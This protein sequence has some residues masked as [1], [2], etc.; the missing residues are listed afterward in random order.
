MENQETPAQRYR[1]SEKCLLA[2]KKY[3]ENKG[4]QT[5]HD[6]YIKNKEKINERSK[7]RYKKLNEARNLPA[8]QIST[9]VDFIQNSDISGNIII[10]E[11]N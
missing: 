10:Y 6:Y 5:A 2:R 8:S 3:Y 11:N 7:Q 9:I 4:K 1:N